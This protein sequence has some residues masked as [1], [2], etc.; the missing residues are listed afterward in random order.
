[1]SNGLYEFEMPLETAVEDKVFTCGLQV[2]G[3][4][5]TQTAKLDVFGKYQRT[6]NRVPTSI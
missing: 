1:M 4:R 2:D 6:Q 5:F 3:V